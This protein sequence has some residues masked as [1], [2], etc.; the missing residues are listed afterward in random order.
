MAPAPHD[1]LGPG[2][3]GAV[4]VRFEVVYSERRQS[5]GDSLC[6]QDGSDTDGVCPA[7]LLGDAGLLVRALATCWSQPHAGPIAR[8]LAESVQQRL[9]ARPSPQGQLAR[10]GQF[11][12]YPAGAPRRQPPKPPR[13]LE[14][15]DSVRWQN[16]SSRDDARSGMG[17]L[18]A[19]PHRRRRRAAF[20]GRALR[21]QSVAHLAAG[22]HHQRLGLSLCH[23]CQHLFGRHLRPPRARSR[24]NCR[25]V[26]WPVRRCAQQ[27]RNATSN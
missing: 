10:P 6:C 18:C 22:D 1:S 20:R 23:R 8:T 9:S 27:A 7:N 14:V 3:F 11:G 19:G 15:P 25:R 17:T 13:L 26:L 5:S 24:S 2:R 16:L 21:R 4:G 12:W